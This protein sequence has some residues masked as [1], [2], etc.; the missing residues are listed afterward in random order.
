MRLNLLFVRNPVF[1][2]SY[3]LYGRTSGFIRNQVVIRSYS[4]FNLNLRHTN[5]R[6]ISG[7]YSNWPSKLL[8]G[9][10]TSFTVPYTVIWSFPRLQYPLPLSGCDPVFTASYTVIWSCSRFHGVLYLLS[11]RFQASWYLVL[12]SGQFPGF[13]IAC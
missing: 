12:L 4:G 7:L 9:R 10:I 8:F 6:S 5:I 1:A 2:I 13:T 11:G 3:F